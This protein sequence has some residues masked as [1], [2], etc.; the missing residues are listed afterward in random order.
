[1]VDNEEAL[2]VRVDVERIVR[3]HVGEHVDVRVVCVSVDWIEID[4]PSW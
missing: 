2:V 3:E 4:S 1:M